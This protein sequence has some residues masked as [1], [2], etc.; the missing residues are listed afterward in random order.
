MGKVK[1]S[2]AVVKLLENWG[3]DHI[4][5]IPGDSIDTMVEALR[6]EESKIKFYTVRHEEV[7]SLAAAAYSKLT[8]K[9]GVCLAIGGPGAIHLLNG[10]Y[11]AKMDHVP[12]L[13]LVG[14]IPS[15]LTGTDYFQEV[16]T[17]ELFKDV[18]VY[19]KK[20][21][22]AESFPA[23]VNQAI[24]TA[25][26]K[27]GVAVL[28]I[29]DDIPLGEI[30]DSA[31]QLSTIFE[32]KTPGLVQDDLNDAVAL[33]NNATRP[34]ILAGVGAKNA[35]NELKAFAE[36]IDAPVAI[37]LPGKGAISDLHPNFIGN[38]GK[39]GTKPA[40][41]AMKSSDLLIMIGTDYP[42]AAYLPE[43]AKC[44]QI[45][46][47]PEK[48]GKRYA[49]TN[50]IVGDAAEA[51]AYLTEHVTPVS[52]RPFL[53][54]CQDNM[55]TW[56]NWMNEDQ[57]QKKSPIAPEALMAGIE[58][59]SEDDTIYSVDVGTST[60]WSTRYLRL[61]DN[62][63]FIVS[64]WL[65]TMGCGLPGA[66]AAKQTFPDRQA[67]AITGDGAFAMVMQDF[68]T[69]VHYKMPIIVV[70]LNNK[71]LAFIK[72][73]QQSAGQLKYAVDFGDIDYAKFAKACGGKGFRIQKYE[74]LQ[75][76][77]EQAKASDVPVILDVAVDVN[78]A[79]LPGKIVMD[80]AK[81]YA[82]FTAKSIA[83]NHKMEKMPPM[84]TVMRRFL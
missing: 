66:I 50:G 47:D 68:A 70:V 12:M 46:I 33:I 45:D 56:W 7:A 72:Y 32:K 65:G 25:Y 44:V 26:T 60:V 9:I 49:V 30:S 34:V 55:K 2:D 37:T 78:A 84:K 6:K 35:K 64:A 73:E 43:G 4:Y 59:I 24:R 23:V 8:G 61:R 11:D 16:D 71:Q 1:A 42:Y 67:I 28:S 77:L 14:H 5:G 57:D 53:K 58:S 69:A 83:E 18:A 39:I 63:D 40:Y 52:D 81:G 80:E 75:P 76:A 29:P 3:I 41:R 54:T 36:R 19:N 20:I 48:I 21:T 27:R 13:V 15:R 74:E 17:V 10:M 38:I 62:Q 51:L 82:R 22:S 79:P 31:P